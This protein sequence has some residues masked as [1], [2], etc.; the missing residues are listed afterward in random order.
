MDIDTLSH[1]GIS[2]QCLPTIRLF[3]QSY[4]M[5]TSSFY[6]STLEEF[7][8]TARMIRDRWWGKY[9]EFNIVFTE[10]DDLDAELFKAFRINESNLY[11]FLNAMND[12]SNREKIVALISATERGNSFED[13]EDAIVFCRAMDYLRE[14]ALQDHYSAEAQGF[15]P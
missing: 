3:A 15:Y 10:G 12:W 4:G 9:V 5:C 14:E 13:I 7:N 8:T 2:S 11:K 6:F 1:S